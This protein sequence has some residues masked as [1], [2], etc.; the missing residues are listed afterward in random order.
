MFGASAQ[1]APL[2]GASVFVIDPTQ[3]Q[4]TLSGNLKAFGELS[5]PITAQDPGSLTASYTGTINANVGSG[6]IQFTGSSLIEAQTN[7]VPQQ[8]AVGGAAGSA[9]A[10]YG[11]TAQ[12]Q[13]FGTT[14]TVVMAVRNLTLDLTSP[15]VP[16]SSGSFA[17]TSLEFTFSTNGDGSIDYDS[18]ALGEA[19]TAGL[20][21]NSTDAASTQATLTT[22]GTVQVLTIPI[23]M[24]FTD[25][26]GTL[27]GTTLNMVGQIV[28]TQTALPPPV[29]ASI[30]V[31]NQTVSL[32]AQN[33]TAQSEVF[34]STDLKTWSFEPASVMTS[35]SQT[36]FTFPVSAGAAF[37]RVRQ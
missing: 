20:T 22:T 26:S 19:D 27:D 36:I 6:T 21:G 1:L 33:A 8:P 30:S 9:P 12:Q 14:I 13:F 15:V 25:G 31:T 32:A 37:L 24:T 18:P 35:G 10:D 17:A 11:G 29:I 16:L 28:A 2:K 4:V 34:I 3:S 23:N 5:A 7:S